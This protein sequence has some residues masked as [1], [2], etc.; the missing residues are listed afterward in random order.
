MGWTDKPKDKIIEATKRSQ[1]QL[2]E[3]TDDEQM[4]PVGITDQPKS[5]QTGRR[6]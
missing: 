3:A 4:K 5:D 1:E 2:G 6:E